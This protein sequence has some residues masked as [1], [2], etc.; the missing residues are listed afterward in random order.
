MKVLFFIIKKEL[1]EIFR[2]KSTFILLLLP[3]I[4]FPMLSIGISSFS[5]SLERHYSISIVNHGETNKILDQFFKSNS[6]TIS[7]IP[8]DN[9]FNLLVDNRIDCIISEDNNRISLYYNSS[10]FSSLS[11]ATQLGEMVQ[12]FLNESD[13]SNRIIHFVLQDENEKKINM[14]GTVT[15]MIAPLAFVLF[16]FQA[17]ASISNDLIAGEKER[18]TFEMLLLSGVKKYNIYIGKLCTIIVIL[19]LEA[20]VCV[21]SL[22]LTSSNSITE[23]FDDNKGGIP[24]IVSCILCFIL[25][26]AVL[27]STVSL[28]SRS[29][30]H[31][32]ILNE[33]VTIIPVFISIAFVSGVIPSNIWWYALI[34][35]FNIIVLFFN[36][37]NGTINL[38]MLIVAIIIT[39]L[40]IIVIILRNCKYIK[41]EQ[42]II[43]RV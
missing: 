24:C 43:N 20:I 23:L 3:S 17:C 38:W 15:F 6:E 8:S 11:K 10:S 14:N 41:S 16:L 12:S 32:Q 33:L 13:Y 29:M 37:L 25:I 28:R 21:L 34:P 4:V 36:G 42:V 26:S 9:P 18:R 5:G 40:L 2:D 30:K 39:L 19:T 7:I 1:I 22:I 35:G 31:S 27:S